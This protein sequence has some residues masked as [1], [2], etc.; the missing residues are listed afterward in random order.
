MGL[1]GAIFFIGLVVSTIKNA[2]IVMKF[3]NNPYID[4]FL[5]E[6]GKAL[7]ICVILLLFT[8]IF[9]HNMYRPTW[10][11]VA[12]W[13]ALASEFLKLNYVVNKSRF[14]ILKKKLKL[15]K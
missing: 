15:G 7:L 8:G 14:L 9:G 3:M 4:K 1:L 10:L 13:S 6:L 5:P 2:I 12:A 11:W